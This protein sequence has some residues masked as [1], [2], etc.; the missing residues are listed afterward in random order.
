MFPDGSNDGAIYSEKAHGF[1]RE[2]NFDM[3]RLWFF[4]WV[5]SFRQENKARN[6][7]LEKELA[8]A[9]RQYSEFAKIDPLCLKLC[10]LLIPAIR[11]SPGLLQTDLYKIFPQFERG[12]LSYVLYFAA[13]HGKIKRTKKGRTYSLSVT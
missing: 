6:G 11:A 9:Q 10:A 5:E 3:A 12:Q 1:L 8:E 2:G 13:E 4:K 7:G